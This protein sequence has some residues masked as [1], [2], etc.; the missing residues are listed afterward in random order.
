MAR[1]RMLFANIKK[2]VHRTITSANGLVSFK[3]NVEMPLKVTCEFIPVQDGSGD[4]SPD[5]DRPISGWTG[6]EIKE[7]GKNLLDQSMVLSR[8]IINSSSKK[9]TANAG[10]KVFY[11]KLKPNT[12]YIVSHA[13]GSVLM[14]GLTKVMPATNVQCYGYVVLTN[15]YDYAFNSGDYKYVCL[16]CASGTVQVQLELGQTATSYQAFKGKTIPITFTDPTTGDPI[17]VYGGTVTLNEDGSVDLVK[18]W[19]RVDAANMTFARFSSNYED[20]DNN[21]YGP[22]LNIGAVFKNT[23]NPTNAPAY[24]NV[25][26][27][28][29]GKTGKIFAIS[30][31]LFLSIYSPTTL[32]TGSEVL[33]YLSSIGFY[34]VGMLLTPQTYHF[35]NIGQL[36]SFLGA[37]NIWHNMNGSIT[38]EYYNYQ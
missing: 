22:V 35:D 6:C 16:S 26:K 7:S 5:N 11:F 27:A 29:S 33:A 18:T 37:N 38:A 13:H 32:S 36:Q 17:T 25:A 3:S 2:L 34:V 10:Y 12:N 1:R 9:I 28:G 8:S 30:G 19:G 14:F 21:I 20:R 31:Q 23:V 24:S 4:P 15:Y